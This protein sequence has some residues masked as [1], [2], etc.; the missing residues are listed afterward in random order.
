MLLDLLCIVFVLF[1]IYIV[2]GVGFG[3]ATT[4]F[5]GERITLKELLKFSLLW[6]NFFI[7]K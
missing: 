1:T 3:L 6:I 4:W 5:A 2:I 7:R